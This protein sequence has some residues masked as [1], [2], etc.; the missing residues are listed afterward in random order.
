[1]TFLGTAQEYN[2]RLKIVDEHHEGSQMTQQLQ[3]RV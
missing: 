3:K 2:S 1:M